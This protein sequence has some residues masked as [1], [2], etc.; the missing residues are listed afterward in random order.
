MKITKY[1]VESVKINNPLSL[2]CVSD[3]HGRNPRRVV[4]ALKGMNPD[5][6]LLAGDIFEVANNRMK[7]RNENAMRFINEIKEIAPI[8]YTFGN[9]EIY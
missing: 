8:Y 3:L 6:I 1:T 9:H 2:A 4:D 5:L 7:E